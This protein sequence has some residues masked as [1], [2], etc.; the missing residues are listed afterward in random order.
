VPVKAEVAACNGQIG[1]NG[2]LFAAARGQQGAVVSNAQAQS[3]VGRLGG[4]AADLAEQ[5]QFTW[6][7]S[8]QGMGLL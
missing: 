3:A 5:G 6:S 1:G 7:T 2:Q 8:G 4:P